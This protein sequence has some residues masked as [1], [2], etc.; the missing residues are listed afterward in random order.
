MSTSSLKSTVLIIGAT[1]GIG[2]GLVRR[3]HAEGKTVIATGRRQDRLDALAKELPGLK[4]ACFDFSDIASLPGVLTDLTTKHPTLDTVIISAGVQT[5]FSLKDPTAS[6]PAGVATQVALNVTAPIILCQQLVPF[7]LNSGKPCSICIIGSALAFAPLPLMPIYCSTKS[8][9]HTF[10]VSLR[11][12][13]VG[14]NVE[15][16]E[17]GPPWVGETELGAKHEEIMIANL[18]GPDKAPKPMA[19]DVY[20]DGTMKGLKEGKA[21]VGVGFGEVAFKTWRGAF[22]PFLKNFHIKG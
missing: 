14:T 20:L 21:E 9:I 1:A 5:Y 17:L 2:R 22:G 12:E 15:V 16:V 11:A 19:L 18:G 6:T 4:T 3:I 8:A 13:L 10:C 7:F